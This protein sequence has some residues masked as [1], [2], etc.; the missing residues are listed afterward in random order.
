MQELTA[1]DVMTRELV[2]VQP[3]A[4]L[5]EIGQ[6]MSEHHVHRVLVGEGRIVQGVITTFDL[7]RVL[8]GS[9]SATSGF[10]RYTG[11]RRAARK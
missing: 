8:P 4:T 6:A 10:T 2:M 11:Y 9:A 1:A 5:D 3:D 7:L